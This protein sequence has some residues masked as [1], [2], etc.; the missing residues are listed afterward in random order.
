LL[1]H[2]SNQT[3]PFPD[4]DGGLLKGTAAEIAST[5]AVVAGLDISKDGKILVAANFENDS[6][7][8]VDTASRQVI[9]EVK[10]FEP[11]DTVATGEYPYDVKIVS[12][13]SG[14]AIKAFV[15]SQ[16]DDE[17]LAVDL[18]TYAISRMPVGAQPNKMFLSADQRR[19]YVA[20]GNNDSVSEIDTR[21]NRVIRTLS[22]ARPGEKYQGSNPNCLALSPDQKTLYVTLGGENAV[23]VL[24]L[25][26]G[27]V[28]GRMPTGWYPNSVS[29][30]KD[31]SK[32]FVV[33][34]KGNAGPNPDGGRTTAAGEARNT[35]AQNQYIL[36]LQ[37][38]GIATIPGAQPPNLIGSY[39][40]G[41]S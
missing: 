30:S 6:I 22:I 38:S 37:K 14:K 26:N 8:V 1:G 18:G 15:S 4:Y 35:T 11:G 25:Q 16:R 39:S 17:V 3:A 41:K 40:P 24:N 2:N 33:N 7:S 34:L 28:A 12:N 10:F 27:R 13:D 19:L 5:G 23:A 20:N 21:N 9:K 36:A 31:G 29:V 32:L